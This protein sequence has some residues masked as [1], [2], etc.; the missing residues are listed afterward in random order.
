M[1]AP[2]HLPARPTEL[3]IPKSLYAPPVRCSAWSGVFHVP[4]QQVRVQNRRIENST[5]CHSGIRRSLRY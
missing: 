2:A 3:R 5:F 4:P 1:N